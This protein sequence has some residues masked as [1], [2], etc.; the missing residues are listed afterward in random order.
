MNSQGRG[1]P[2]L[3][4]LMYWLRV[5]SRVGILLSSLY[6]GLHFHI[7]S[8]IFEYQVVSEQDIEI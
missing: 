6:F 2:A 4:R 7:L 1:K 8:S 5:R 3:V